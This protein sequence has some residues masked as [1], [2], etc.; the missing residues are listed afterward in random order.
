MSLANKAGKYRMSLANKPSPLKKGQTMD[1]VS[2]L[3]Q[4]VR[5]NKVSDLAGAYA[6]TLGMVAAEAGLTDAQLQR[7][8]DSVK[9]A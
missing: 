4:A 8:I 5:D 7:M 9:G 1:K 3:V 6:F 2:E